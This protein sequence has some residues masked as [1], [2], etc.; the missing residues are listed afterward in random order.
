MRLFRRNCWKRVIH[1]WRKCQPKAAEVQLPRFDH[2]ISFSL[3]LLALFLFGC[4]CWCCF[5]FCFCFSLSAVRSFC[6]C[7]RF[8]ENACH[9]TGEEWEERD[10]LLLPHSSRGRASIR[11]AQ[12][13]LVIPH[14]SIVN[15][16]KTY[17]TFVI[18]NLLDLIYIL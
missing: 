2:F 11:R 17:S 18:L 6:G 5:H 9:K 12:G 16:I 15:I 13:S 3:G 14:W 1:C 7:G 8:V 10:M 4:W